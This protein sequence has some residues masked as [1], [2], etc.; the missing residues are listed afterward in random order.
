MS[1]SKRQYLR[2]ADLPTP[3]GAGG[4]GAVLA[5]AAIPPEQARPTP[6]APFGLYLIASGFERSGPSPSAFARVGWFPG[7]GTPAS[8]T[9]ELQWSRASDYSVAPI[10]KAT[11]N[12]GEATGL[13]P[14]VTYLRVRAVVAGVPGTYSGSLAV[15]ISA[16]SDAP[17]PAPTGLTTAWSGRTGDLEVRCTVPAGEQV[18]GVQFRIYASAG[19][20]LL[21][22][23]GPLTTGQYVWTLA[24]QRADRGVPTGPVSPTAHIIANAVSWAGNLSTDVAATATLAAPATPGGVTHLWQGDDGTAA[25][26]WRLSWADVSD[27]A[28]YRLTIDGLARS[29]PAPATSYPYPF[30][31]NQD[32]HSG[33]ADPVLG[34]SLVAVNALEQASAAATGTATNAAPPTVSISIAGYLNTISISLGTTAARDADANPYRV[35]VYRDA[36]L[37]DTLRLAAPTGTYQLTDGTAGDYSADVAVVDRFGQ[38]SAVSVSNTIVDHDPLTLAE[39]RAGIRYRDDLGTNEDTLKAAL[40]DDNRL[41]GGVT[42]T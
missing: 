40:A 33:N 38:A 2:R 12:P 7:P 23:V 41:S 28:F 39:L 18:E 3:E 13:A 36:A 16:L 5:T 25:A 11:V 31:L 1:A 8:A 42:Y 19:G 29:V 22:T 21:R 6:S 4:A 32:E 9:Y 30:G 26:D 37:I 14:G 17:P 15:T 20:A 10:S 35:R 34:Y 27:A 24:Q